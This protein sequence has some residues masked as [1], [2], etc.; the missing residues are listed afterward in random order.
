MCP[1]SQ[2]LT[3]IY[4]SPHC[5]LTPLL[6]KP[7]KC[8]SLPSLA[9]YGRGGGGG[10]HHCG[11]SFP[12]LSPSRLSSVY[13]FALSVSLSPFSPLFFL[14]S[15]SVLFLSACCL[16]IKVDQR[17]GYWSQFKWPRSLLIVKDKEDSGKRKDRQKPSVIER[18]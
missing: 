2:M 9:L 11:F 16:L 12:S 15:G 8:P 4:S 3:L 14:Y 6:P 10:L 1:H 18:K 17:L 5:L 7:T 13:S